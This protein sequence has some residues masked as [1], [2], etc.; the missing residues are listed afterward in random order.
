MAIKVDLK[1]S[2]VYGWFKMLL[3]NVFKTVG[4]IKKRVVGEICRRSGPGG[5][6]FS[7]ILKVP[8]AV[9]L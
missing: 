4:A 5:N 7:L 6:I 9:K 1:G 3:E 2:L 8:G